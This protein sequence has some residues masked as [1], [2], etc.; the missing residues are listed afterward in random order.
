MPNLKKNYIGYT[1]EAHASRHVGCPIEGL[2]LT[3]QYDSVLWC[4]RGFPG[5]LNSSPWCRET[6][7]SRTSPNDSI[8]SSRR[9]CANSEPF[10]SGFS[11]SKNKLFKTCH[12]YL[13]VIAQQQRFPRLK[14]SFKCTFILRL[15]FSAW[16][17]TVIGKFRLPIARLSQSTNRQSGFFL[18]KDMKNSRPRDGPAKVG[19]PCLFV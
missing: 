18:T 1:R 17:M 16:L 4:S 7:F 2:P 11:P 3:P 13:V 10:S 12:F 14:I 5:D 15:L 9:T 8:F 6:P 19:S